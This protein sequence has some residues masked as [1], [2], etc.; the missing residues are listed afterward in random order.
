MK[1]GNEA[2]EPSAAIPNML[3]DHSGF[4]D[5]RV[6]G[7]QS[8]ITRAPFGINIKKPEPSFGAV[9][10]GRQASE[11]GSVIAIVDKSQAIARIELTQVEGSVGGCVQSDRLGWDSVRTF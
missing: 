9:A 2:F 3:K 4:G 11:P 8:A 6:P 7:H 1:S 10:I 5:S